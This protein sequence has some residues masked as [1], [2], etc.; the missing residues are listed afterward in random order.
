MIKIKE[1]HPVLGAWLFD[2]K[3]TTIKEIK[4]NDFFN[5][6][7]IG[8]KCL[9]FKQTY[10]RDLVANIGDYVIKNGSSLYPMS[11]KTFANFYDII[12]D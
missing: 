5:N 6:I 12:E 7:V 1:K 11:A 9:Y 2:G 8:N 4:E 10:D 3:E